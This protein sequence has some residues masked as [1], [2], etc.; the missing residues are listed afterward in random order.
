[1]FQRGD[2]LRFFTEAIRVGQRGGSGGQRTCAARYRCTFDELRQANRL[3]GN[4]ALQPLVVS[5]PDSSLPT[6]PDLLDD[7]VMFDPMSRFHNTLWVSLIY[8]LVCC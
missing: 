4:R 1:M 7:H 5:R 3:D 8:F 2:D 6:L